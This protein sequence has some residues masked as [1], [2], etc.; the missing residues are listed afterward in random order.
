MVMTAEP[1]IPDIIARDL[2]RREGWT[3]AAVPALVFTNDGTLLAMNPAAASLQRTGADIA[4]AAADTATVAR[5]APQATTAKL[6]A[7]EALLHLDLLAMPRPDSGMVVVIVQDRTLETNL[8]DALIESRHRFRDL[9][10]L[11][12][13]FGWEI[14]ADGICTFVSQ[15]GALGYTA[16]QF[17]GAPLAQHAVE[18]SDYLATLPL[19]SPVPVEDVE[20]LLRCADG[21]HA[22]HLVSSIP[23][24][25][26]AGQRSGARGICRDV[27]MEREQERSLA[28]A[29][30]RERLVARVLE[31]FRSEVAPSKAL[32]LAAEALRHGMAASGCQIISA[33]P[34]LVA[35]EPKIE[36]LARNGDTGGS[37]ELQLACDR[38][39][40]D[41]VVT[42]EVRDWLVLIVPAWFREAANG[43]LLL[44][45]LD[46]EAP[47]DE[48]DRR[49]ANLFATHV[50]FAIEQVQQH[51]RLISVAQTDPLTGVL[52]R[53]GFQEEVRRR[54]ERS[55]RRGSE[56]ALMYVD[57]DN[58][59]AV[60]DRHGHTVGDE[61]LLFV[62]DLLRTNIRP[63]DLIGRLGG[64]EFAL[65]LDGAGREVAEKRAQLLVAGSRALRRFSG[66]VQQPLGLSIGIVIHQP[67]NP[68]TLEELVARADRVMYEV[69]RSGRSG[70]AVAQATT[71]VS[72]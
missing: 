24:Y 22:P 49:L 2:L 70:F 44:W 9:L 46:D 10:E 18:G 37:A 14:D 58:F 3:L 33:M 1:D 45:R 68:E 35:A 25:D 20:V 16:E 47:W 11:S 19:T 36:I 31:G 42:A 34:S 39:A 53:R 63:H 21:S 5:D 57:L 17:L 6:T 13:A 7:H 26:H 72:S 62:R 8:R 51:R 69:K 64:D 43:A 66:S 48:D 40:A 32:A 65:W 23:L 12:G 27:T 55:Q 28:R 30:Q 61:A 41:E 50:G 59:K 52:N 71:P 38:I 54:M 15:N 67:T 4:A 56:S 29:L 60:N